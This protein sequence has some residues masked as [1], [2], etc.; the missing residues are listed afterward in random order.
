MKSY[1]FTLKFPYLSFQILY[2]FGFIEKKSSRATS[3]ILRL[4]KSIPSTAASSNLFSV[5][6]N[7][8]FSIPQ[9]M[10]LILT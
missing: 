10:N 2:P 9:K 5:E 6:L 3:W 8:L 4:L 7:P 1:L